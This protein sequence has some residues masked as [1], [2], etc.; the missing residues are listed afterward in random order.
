MMHS[1][2]D[3]LKTAAYIAPEVQLTIA[4]GAHHTTGDFGKRFAAGL[5]FVY[6]P[7]SVG[8]PAER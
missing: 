2:A 7:R 4:E 5:L 8:A 1:L 3:N 6:A